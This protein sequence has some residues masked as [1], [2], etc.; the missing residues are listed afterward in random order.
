MHNAK[1]VNIQNS[2]ITLEQSIG[3]RFHELDDLE[4]ME[5]AIENVTCQISRASDHHCPIQTYFRIPNFISTFL[6]KFRI[7]N[8]TRSFFPNLSIS[9]GNGV[10]LFSTSRPVVFG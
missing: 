8:F 10:V 7:E 5:C 6:A 3:M 2:V 4:I 9:V 1:I